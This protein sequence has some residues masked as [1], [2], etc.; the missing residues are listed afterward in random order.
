M[1]R[2]GKL[3]F[4]P[5]DVS[6]VKR[7]MRNLSILRLVHAFGLAGPSVLVQ[8]YIIAT[9]TSSSHSSVLLFPAG[10]AAA[11]IGQS[12]EADE[13]EK[14]IKIHLISSSL[15]LFNICWGK[16][17]LFYPFP[18]VQAFF[19]LFTGFVAEIISVMAHFVP[20][21]LRELL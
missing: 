12:A 4:A 8:G 15:S 1:Y 20:V 10:S 9:A 5:V 18:T 6:I 16:E 21:Q 13:G 19:L 11:Q 2:Y 7:E 17:Q 3:L 14:N